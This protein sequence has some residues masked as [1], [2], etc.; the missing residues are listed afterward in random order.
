MSNFDHVSDLVAAREK[1]QNLQARLETA[2]A[3]VDAWKL[4][5]NVDV[6]P[7]GN[8]FELAVT[9]NVGQRGCDFVISAQEISSF[10]GDFSSLADIVADKAMNYLLRAE[11]RRALRDH[12]VAAC[13]N[14]DALSSRSSL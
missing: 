8:S 12:F 10:R 1:I 14:I 7:I 9:A 3:D 13:A 5:F 2:K 11:V 4:T 6:R